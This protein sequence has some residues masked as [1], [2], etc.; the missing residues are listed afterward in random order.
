MKKTDDGDNKSFYL[1]VSLIDELAEMKK[2]YPNVSESQYARE[3][4][5]WRLKKEKNDF[6]EQLVTILVL[7]VAGCS[8]SIFSILSGE[9]MMIFLGMGSIAL[10]VGY[11]GL[12]KLIN[13]WRLKKWILR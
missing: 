10:L 8:I 11:A 13:R 1:P 9:N 7:I 3:G 2:R 6:V 12:F 4:L 5:E